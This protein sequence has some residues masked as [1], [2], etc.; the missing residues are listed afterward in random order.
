MPDVNALLNDPRYSALTDDKKVEVLTKFYNK[1]V[2]QDSR[3]STL[4]DEQKKKAYQLFMQK[5]SPQAQATPQQTVEQSPQ[6]ETPYKPQPTQLSEYN[7]FGVPR[8]TQTQ[9]DASLGD[10][11]AQQRLSDIQKQTKQETQYMERESNELGEA[12][13]DWAGYGAMAAMAM[14]STMGG[15]SLQNK[16]KGVV[17]RA[18][19]Y[20]N[21]LVV[22]FGMNLLKAAASP[23]DIFTT[24]KHRAKKA[25]FFE[26]ASFA[27]QEPNEPGKIIE[28]IKH[29][30]IATVADIGARSAVASAPI[31]MAWLADP[32]VGTY[33]SFQTSTTDKFINLS[34]ERPEASRGKAAVSATAAGVFEAAMEHAGNKLGIGRTMKMG[35]AMPAA[36]FADMLKGK[37]AQTA[38]YKYFLSWMGEAASEGFEEV[39]SFALEYITD[40]LLGLQEWNSKEFY[41][42][43]IEN[44]AAGTAAGGAQG[45]ATAAFNYRNTRP[46][47]NIESRL[48]K[49]AEFKTSN[50]ADPKARQA[51][52][53]L[54]AIAKNTLDAIGAGKNNRGDIA[55]QLAAENITA[56]ERAKSGNIYDSN[57][58]S[59]LLYNSMIMDSALAAYSI[60]EADETTSKIGY[61]LARQSERIRELQKEYRELKNAGHSGNDGTAEGARMSEIIE[62]IVP[63]AIDAYTQNEE[64][65]KIEA[66]EG[67]K[68]VG[69]T[70]ASPD[71]D[72]TPEPEV[73][74]APE[75]ETTTKDYVISLIEKAKQ[76]LDDADIAAAKK[77]AAEFSAQERTDEAMD[78]RMQANE[79]DTEKEKAKPRAE[80]QQVDDVDG[81][82]WAELKDEAKALGIK[83]PGQ[84]KKDI[85][86]DRVRKARQEMADKEARAAEQAKAK[87]LTPEEAAELKAHLDPIIKN[88]KATDDINELNRLISEARAHPLRKKKAG[89]HNEIERVA[90]DIR[91][92]INKI[93]EAAEP[94]KI[95]SSKGMKVDVIQIDQRDPKESGVIPTERVGKNE[96]VVKANQSIPITY[97]LV[98]ISDL[99]TS[100]NEMSFEKTK[101]YPQ[102][103]QNRSREE[104]RDTVSETA[105]DLDP[106]L[107]AGAAVASD[108]R[109]IVVM[110]ENG[111]MFVMSGN[112]RTM[113]L[114]L[115]Q[116][117]EFGNLD[118]YSA[119]IRKELHNFGIKDQD[120][121]GMALV[122][123]YHGDGNLLELSRLL[124]E[125]E[126]QAKSKTDIAT[127]DA[128]LIADAKNDGK[129]VIA[130]LDSKAKGL[131]TEGNEKFIEE[132]LNEFIQDRTEYV[133]SSGEYTT[134][135][136]DRIENA[137]FMYIF[138]GDKKAR[139]LL[140]AL[141]EVGDSP[142]KSIAKAII[143]NVKQI[144]LLRNL[145]EQHNLEDYDITQDILDAMTEIARLRNEGIP[146]ED[147]IDQTD[148]FSEGESVI[149]EHLRNFYIALGG[150]R[151]FKAADEFIGG[152]YASA[153]AALDPHQTDVFA[154]DYVKTKEEFIDN[155]AKEWNKARP[156]DKAKGKKQPD[157]KPTV[158]QGV[159]ADTKQTSGETPKDSGKPGQGRKI[160]PVKMSQAE[161]ARQMHEALSGKLDAAQIDGIIA[162]MDAMMQTY[163][164]EMGITIDQAYVENVHSVDNA[165][166]PEEKPSKPLKQ[167]SSKE[168]LE[169][170]RQ[171]AEVR[172]QYEGTDK[173]LKAPNGKPTKLTERQWLQVRTPNFKAWF[174]DWEND[175]K[176]ASKVVDENGEPRVVWHGTENGGFTEFSK[177]KLGSNTGAPSARRGFFFAGKEST[178]TSVSYRGDGITETSSTLSSV[179]ESVENLAFYATR[180]L[181][182]IGAT[183][184]SD[185]YSEDLSFD[186]RHAAYKYSG[187]H[188]GYERAIISL[189]RNIEGD[190]GNNAKTIIEYGYSQT[191]IDD[192]IESLRHA[193]DAI[194]GIRTDFSF[195]EPDETM[196]S[197][198]LNVRNPIEHDYYGRERGISF[199]KMLSTAQEQGD[200]GAVFKNI[201]DG[202]MFDDIFVAFEPE[203]IK[204]ATGNMGTYSQETA[205][206]FK[207]PG[208]ISLDGIVQGYIE[209]RKDGT[210]HIGFLDPDVSTG[211]HEQAHLGRELLAK[212][213]EKSPEWR[214]LYDA[215]EEWCGVENGVWTTE[216]EEK[217]ARGFEKYVYEGH[218]PNAK[219][220]TLY[221]KLKEWMRA[222]IDKLK[223]LADIKLDKNIL[224]VYDALF[225]GG[226][227]KNIENKK[228]HVKN[229]FTAEQMKSTD[230]HKL[231]AALDKVGDNFGCIVDTKGLGSRASIL[232]TNL[233]TGKVMVSISRVADGYEVNGYHAANNGEAISRANDILGNVLRQTKP[234]AQPQQRISSADT[235]INASRLPASFKKIEWKPNTRNADIGGGRFDNATEYLAGLGV[236]N[237]IYDPYNR[238]D[239]H[240]KE[241]IEKIRDGQSDTATVNNVLN[242]IAEKEARAQVIQNA[243]NAIKQ[244]GIAYFLTYEGDQSGV[245]R[246]T[247]KGWQENRKTADYI[248]EVSQYFRDVSTSNGMIVAKSPKETPTILKQETRDD[249]AEARRQME[250]V[251]KQYEGTKDYELTELEERPGYSKGFSKGMTQVH[252]KGKAFHKGDRRVIDMLLEWKKDAES[253]TSRQMLPSLSTQESDRLFNQFGSEI[254]V[255]HDMDIEGK[256]APE[257][258]D[259]GRYYGYDE[260]RVEMTAKEAL[261]SISQIILSDEF[262]E[263]VQNTEDENT[264]DSQYEYSQDY[265]NWI[266]ELINPENPWYVKIVKASDSGHR[267]DFLN[268]DDGSG[269]SRIKYK[270]GYLKAPNGKPTNLNERQ[271]LQV[272]TQNFKDWFGD[273]ENDPKNASKVVD[274]NGEPMVVYHGSSNS[275]SEFSK[276]MMGST[277]T[278]A[279]KK[280]F[281]FA[282][283]PEVASFFAQYEDKNIYPVFLNIKALA[284]TNDA[285]LSRYE[286]M[287]GVGHN[288]RRDV[289]QKAIREGKNG[290]MFLNT[291][292]Y[293]GDR[294]DTFVA[295]SPNQIKS[296]TANVGTF[297][298]TQPSILYQTK[299]KTLLT[300]HNISEEK[301]QQVI[302]QG[303]MPMP[304]LAVINT[305]ETKHDEFGE[306]SLIADPSIMDI[307][308]KN[309]VY[310]QDAWTPM[311]PAVYPRVDESSRADAQWIADRIN[312]RYKADIQ[313]YEI[314]NDAQRQNYTGTIESIIARAA[315]SS[316]DEFVDYDDALKYV[317]HLLK[318]RPLETREEIRVLNDKYGNARYR[319]NTAEEV[320]KMMRHERNRADKQ[321]WEVR[322]LIGKIAPMFSSMAAVDKNRWRLMSKAAR[323]SAVE[324]IDV[325]LQKIVKYSKEKRIEYRSYAATT[326]V[327]N[328]IYDIAKGRIADVRQNYAKDTDFAAFHEIIKK[329]KMIPTDMF[330][331][332]PDRVVK[333]NE[334]VS[335]IVPYGTDNKALKALKDAGLNIA[336]YEKEDMDGRHAKVVH[337]AEKSA[338]LFQAQKSAPEGTVSVKTAAERRAEAQET[339][340]R[341]AMM[342]KSKLNKTN[343]V[344]EMTELMQKAVGTW[345]RLMYPGAAPLDGLEEYTMVADLSE[346]DPDTKEY[347]ALARKLARKRAADRKFRD[348]MLDNTGFSDTGDIPFEN[349][350]AS[351][352]AIN[353]AAFDR[354]VKDESMDMLIDLIPG[355]KEAFGL[356]EGESIDL[357]LLQKIYDATFAS[358]PEVG[359]SKAVRPFRLPHRR[360][361]SAFGKAGQK[362]IDLGYK[363]TL[364]MAEYEL[365]YTPKLRELHELIR[366]N[367]NNRGKKYEGDALKAISETMMVIN[368]KQDIADDQKLDAIKKSMKEWSE[369][370]NEVINEKDIEGIYNV[371]RDILDMFRDFIVKFNQDPNHKKIGIREDYGD[372]RRY[373]WLRAAQTSIEGGVLLHAP[374]HVKQRTKDELNANYD[375]FSR[376]IYGNYLGYV[377]LMSKYMAFYDFAE[378]LK[379]RKMRYIKGNEA[380]EINLGSPMAR[381]MTKAQIAAFE[382]SSMRKYIQDYAQG[383]IGIQR[384][385]KK[386]DKRMS[387][388]VNNVYSSALVF[389]VGLTLKNFNQRMLILSVVDPHV[390]GQVM[391][392]YSFWKGLF[393]RDH[394][395]YPTLSQIMQTYRDANDS[396]IADLVS[397]SKRMSDGETN[398]ISK[399]YYDWTALNGNLLRLS[400]FS[401]AELGNRAYGH[402]A[403]VYQIIMNSPDYKEARAKGMEVHEAMEH[404]LS[405]NNTLREAAITYGGIINAE[406]N[407]DANPAFA[408]MFFNGASGINKIAT[409]VRYGITLANLELRTFGSSSSMKSMLSP[410]MFKLWTSG[411]IKA[412]SLST[413]L[414]SAQI[415]YRALTD[416]NIA[417]LVE[418][419]KVS[420]KDESDMLTIKQVKMV[421]EMIGEQIEIVEKAIRG[422]YRHIVRG[423]KGKLIAGLGLIGF[424][425]AEAIIGFLHNIIV[426]MLPWWQKDSPLDDGMQI[427]LNDVLEL[428]QAT[429]MFTDF[430]LGAGITP[431]LNAFYGS[432][433]TT[434]KDAARW[435]NRGTPFMGHVNQ[436]IREA[437]G[438]YGT[439]Y[440][441]DEIFD[442]ME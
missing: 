30:D 331:A 105:R 282:A 256:W 425:V 278:A 328:D 165:P 264:D 190:V 77:A 370:N 204:S 338:I 174:G 361:I 19:G 7:D 16:D 258:A 52:E 9:I 356:K 170:K 28:A 398:P 434:I 280:G 268:F 309:P 336:F 426:A 123:I 428:S 158:P 345:I 297:D 330:E 409:F 42:G 128:V 265:R 389:N 397:E 236:E 241:A 373:D 176:N 44:F 92:K 3:Y 230:P 207:Q 360:L 54:R 261:S 215:A 321:I 441:V 232:M 369:R 376:D 193:D 34:I 63:L 284:K 175:P 411:E 320:M 354:V 126:A 415:F 93:N 315:I 374:G 304:S 115:R 273:W 393:K 173:W 292:D 22:S 21:D 127:S 146:V 366:S 334:F 306:I 57:F 322:E 108:G 437:T 362:L 442:I 419:S 74:P 179:I 341:S 208:A 342:L 407:A 240:N 422:D 102:E 114:K 216:A 80:P 122:G 234:F 14:L 220:K 177:D 26:G 191:D 384:S 84:I 277:G 435:I 244:D 385:G 260:F 359:D 40:V 379:D 104:T 432:D 113:A 72:P 436:A 139:G 423:S 148:I 132:F 83:N 49:A 8:L 97:A 272:R 86:K 289:L 371:T 350:Y 295:F 103:L 314:M 302:K 11:R 143:E 217:F 294:T 310:S 78:L 344:H 286:L 395:K 163:A 317:K 56:I 31:T 439:D 66:K 186:I 150:I 431:N 85:L 33:L 135:L 5:Y 412:A 387:A 375:S 223:E 305:K 266:W 420:N 337:E 50:I 221:S 212:L 255:V 239:A 235:S 195:G 17:D 151:S 245:G 430:R 29:G 233:E 352:S 252:Y 313:V 37:V 169:A 15:G 381:D 53:T 167:E 401:V 318:I 145:I 20:I 399:L 209:K 48:Q 262:Y 382:D 154:A 149:P 62:E 35:K 290:A 152:Y 89:A 71:V 55:I 70:D 413:K 75:P 184:Y 386:W 185:D 368:S 76:T 98:P 238:T 210:H 396:L 299:N 335:A 183:G 367:Q 4:N 43:M 347:K 144:A 351:L 298:G 166:I 162:V 96:T 242:V 6:I 248:G 293:G 271:W 296:A 106:K 400:P 130:L 355:I 94:I 95:T 424:A 364:K 283:N 229:A 12:K 267:A 259:A 269:D 117:G 414:H 433:K 380:Q 141:K 182:D 67:R 205:N 307:S 36:M 13:T 405:N 133:S 340:I 211:L 111:N 2:P 226:V 383:V 181:S 58:D 91:A 178:S 131:M 68:E 147:H 125:S 378:Y 100:H 32:I 1:Y 61:N 329:I 325:D 408:P 198:F 388:W 417:K 189:L 109:P 79:L 301:L 348:A 243:A 116:A 222:I 199:D 118:E 287:S 88:A 357:K 332:K 41:A 421:R 312:K 153:Q 45:A 87:A 281:W 250:A 263:Y 346:L 285:K 324:S 275:F 69:I 288:K 18:R 224:E 291:V 196:Y 73:S 172:K 319:P 365:L 129:D 201:R 164:D 270:D 157:T 197:V 391:K 171:E 160:K 247:T 60:S 39:G 10:T 47:V 140:S 251:R 440:I 377:Q 51:T 403:G 134:A 353:P 38:A 142:V 65:K 316:T 246:E 363:G 137:L 27:T 410:D 416:S 156:A 138:N 219:L 402:A 372:P 349:L 323:E 406:I 168:I 194:E 358:S 438:K 24:A 101:G 90:G 136:R 25:G 276:K 213:A 202:G 187:D 121:E 99:I 274:E 180:M 192:A 237:V 327:A 206:I 429:S 300:I 59:L 311:H 119:Y 228:L 214:R 394:E 203:Q 81:M 218:A 257:D 390:A 225:G 188:K 392:D 418:K 23:A 253:D 107:L 64:K 339:V 279:A 333:L 200:D 110:D 120:T 82:T 155:Y 124:N 326:D 46:F 308:R 249:I 303:G 427:G 161:Y 112:R 159:G 227:K 231:T 343:N 404:A 254:V